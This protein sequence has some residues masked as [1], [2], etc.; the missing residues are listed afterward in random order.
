MFIIRYLL[1]TQT[2]KLNKILT[3]IELLL[4]ADQ[5]KNITKQT[6]FVLNHISS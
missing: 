6:W 4:T 3:H 1:P 5:R 2:F